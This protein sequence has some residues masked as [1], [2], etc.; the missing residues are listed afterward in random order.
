MKV[1]RDLF[2]LFPVLIEWSR[3]VRRSKTTLAL[4]VLTGMIAGLGN[5]A[6]IAIINTALFGETTPRLVWG[7][8][9]LCALIP[10]SGA[11]SNALLARLTA[12]AGYVMRM[13][14]CHQIISAPLRLLEEIGMPR[15]FATLTDDHI[16]Q[17]LSWAL[18]EDLEEEAP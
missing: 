1:I 10:L 7:F 4:V 3:G 14:L 9:G 13:R 5:T 16:A 15:L 2:Q 8:V 6:L 12:R 17:L 18:L 11:I